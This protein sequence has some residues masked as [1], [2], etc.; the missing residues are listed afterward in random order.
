M[1]L[2]DWALLLVWLGVAMAG[3]WK[4][5]VRIVFT[6]GGLGTGVWLALVAGADL[7]AVIQ[8]HV[9]AAW[10][11]NVAGYTIPVL[12]TAS[13]CFL[14]GWGIESTLT[15]LHLR[16]LNRLAGAVLAGCAAAFLLALLVVS[17]TRFSPAWRD[18]CADSLLLP[19][20][21]RLL[22]VFLELNQDPVEHAQLISQS[23]LSQRGGATTKAVRRGVRC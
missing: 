8:P 15:A 17:G 10:I 14:A 21:M 2:L 6:L 18:L 12:L 3:F 16:W 7:A 9:P 4:G 11:A 23:L 22:D 13:I 19:Y 1:T 20:L 5:A